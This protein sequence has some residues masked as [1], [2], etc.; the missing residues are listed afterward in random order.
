MSNELNVNSQANSEQMRLF[1]ENHR[2]FKERLHELE[3]IEEKESE[4]K[5]R[6]NQSPY[7]KWS[8]LNDDHIDDMIWLA[9]K[10]PRAQAILLFLLKKMDKYNALLCSY[11]VIQETLGI[12]PATVT[13][14]IKVLKDSGFI[15]IFKSGT[16][17]VYIVNKDLAWSSWG[18][19]FKHCK[20][21]ANI[22]LTT[23]ENKEHFNK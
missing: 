18:T 8:K 1:S 14:N 3:N 6:K 4:K 11:Q 12:G 17:N 16:S 2:T 7:L 13:R 15:A 22:I 19:N 9:T 10:H 21:P 23:S 5:K 20:F